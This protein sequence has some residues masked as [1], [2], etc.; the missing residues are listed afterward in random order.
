MAVGS[1]PRWALII[2]RSAEGQPRYV[3]PGLAAAFA[4]I[5]VLLAWMPKA[6]GPV[7]LLVLSLLAASRPGWLLALALNGFFVYLAALDLGGYEPGKRLTG[8][9]YAALGVLMLWA[10]WRNRVVLEERLRVRTRLLTAWLVAAAALSAWFLANAA[11]FREGGD[12]PQRFAGLL[13]FSTLPAVLLV[14]GFRRESLEE[15]RDG[16]VG[17]GLVLAVAIGAALAAGR[18]AEA[19]RLSPISD[20]DP[21]NASLVPTVGAVAALT[22][23]PSS[24]RGFIAQVAVLTV[25][26]G[27]AIASG[28]RGP[29]IALFIA[30]LFL[31]ILGGRMLASLVALVFVL[32]A[33]LGGIVAFSV[34]TSEYLENLKN[35]IQRLKTDSTEVQRDDEHVLPA[36]LPSRFPRQFVLAGDLRPT[37]LEGK[38]RAIL[39]SMSGTIIAVR[40]VENLRANQWTTFSIGINRA[41]LPHQFRVLVRHDGVTDNRFVLRNMRVLFRASNYQLDILSDDPVGYW[42]LGERGGTTVR[43]WSRNRHDGTYNGSPRA[44]ATGALRANGDAAVVFNGVNQA[45]AIHAPAL[46][47]LRA[48]SVEA[49]IFL[50]P[51]RGMK[52]IVRQGLGTDLQY[53]LFVDPASGSLAYYYYDGSF[54][55]IRTPSGA[56]SRRR[57]HH[58]VLVRERDGRTVTFYVDRRPVYRAVARTV[59]V[60]VGGVMGIAGGLSQSQLLRGRVD[61]VAIYRYPLSEDQIRSHFE[62]GRRAGTRAVSLKIRKTAA[63]GVAWT[64]GY[65]LVLPGDRRGALL[66]QWPGLPRQPAPVMPIST[67]SMRWKWISDALTAFPDKPIFGHGIS[68]LPVQSGQTREPRRARGRV[69]PHNDLAEAA[70]SLGL[71]GLIPFVLLILLPA[72]AHFRMDRGA[73]DRDVY[74]LTLGLFVFAFVESNF[75]GEIGA[76]GLLWS[77]C[78]L[79]LGLYADAE[80]SKGAPAFAPSRDRTGGRRDATRAR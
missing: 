74:L 52:S 69:Y 12:E 22:Y 1:T 62:R 65:E 24:R 72:V 68:A 75:S 46:K 77:S 32:G 18:G 27:A 6:A 3:L 66:P 80:R 4:S 58:V 11:L 61:E 19:G 17:L 31:G 51:G 13:V 9:Y 59:P 63:S 45:V 39:T 38:F 23:R 71:L 29:L 57:W 48:V 14:L 41:Q 8:A 43:D 49:W 56:V 79:S 25:L 16:L 37:F 26:V 10:A 50:Y 34:G 30:V 73:M 67:V 70:Y 47:S 55:A 33:G 60:G 78:A 44:S 36:F 20:L 42:R 54:A 7:A 35:E 5:V 76:D 15:L 28:S 40:E 64:D 21:I 53:G 2:S